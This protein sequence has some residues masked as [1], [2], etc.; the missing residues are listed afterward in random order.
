M[1]HTVIGVDMSKN[2]FDAFDAQRK[3]FRSF[4]ND[5]AGIKAFAESLSPHSRIVIESTGRYHSALAGVLLDRKI[6]V[7]IVN[8][9]NVRDFAK[10][11]GTLAKTDKLD[12]RIIAEFGIKMN[13]RTTEAAVSEPFRMLV[14]RRR[15]LIQMI[16]CE[17]SRREGVKDKEILA[18]IERIN[19]SLK[20]EVET[21]DRQIKEFIRQNA[22]YASK[23]E[24]LTA[25]KGVGFITAVSLLAEMPELGKTDKRKIAALAGLAPFN[26][27]SGS[28]RGQRHI[29]GGRSEIRSILYMAAVAATVRAKNGILK[30][31]YN[32]LR[33][34]GKAFKVAIVACMRKL[35]IHLNAILAKNT[36]FYA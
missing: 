13:P 8:P 7:C 31:H 29:R 15:Q 34:N 20:E 27:D 4:A 22:D 3:A 18:S 35:L 11:S 33:K 28:I 30:D 26:C 14:A 23:A 1:D 5:A 25:V 24:M 32:S 6:D 21:I 2:R 36:D 16:N 9:K 17:V 19:L 10:A 12:A